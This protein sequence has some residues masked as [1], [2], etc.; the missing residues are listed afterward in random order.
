[1]RPMNRLQNCRIVDDGDRPPRQ[2]CPFRCFDE[3]AISIPAGVL[4]PLSSLCS[5][6]GPD[7]M[8]SRDP[9]FVKVY[10]NW[11]VTSASRAA[12]SNL[13]LTLPQTFVYITE[14]N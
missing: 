3:A 14:F 10:P 2:P 7:R 12:V 4:L 11:L 6:R 1:M 5:C 8:G 13:P 9:L